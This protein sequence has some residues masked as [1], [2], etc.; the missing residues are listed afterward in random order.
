M[1]IKLN[2]TKSLLVQK[3]LC[4]GLVQSN[5]RLAEL[6]LSD[7]ALGPNG[8]NGLVDFLSSSSCHDLQEL[9]FN[10]N[11]LGTTGGKVCGVVWGGGC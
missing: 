2:D 3:N 9:R 8:M 1:E 6:D 5:S 7:N 11:G 4:K 10:N